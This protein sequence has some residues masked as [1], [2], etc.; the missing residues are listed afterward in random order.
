[1]NCELCGEEVGKPKRVNIEGSTLRVCLN[2]AHLGKEVYDQGGNE[3][4]RNEMMER[5]KRR[6]NRGRR[7]DVLSGS[8]KEVAMDYPDRIRS[9]RLDH[10][11]TQEE[12]ASQIN[13]KKS[14]IAKLEKGDLFPSDSLIKKLESSLH[15]ELMEEYEEPNMSKG[16][17]SSGYTIG[18]IIKQE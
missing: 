15:I 13:E 4:S 11:W 3:S 16:K 2:C 1:M 12:L 6:K 17:S 7:S 18:D 5:I 9:A 14:V 10:S 8:E